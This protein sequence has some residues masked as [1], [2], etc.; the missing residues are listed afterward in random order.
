MSKDFIEFYVGTNLVHRISSSHRLLRGD[1]VN[2]AKVT[3]K[4][5]AVS[6]AIDHSADQ[7]AASVVQTVRIV[8]AKL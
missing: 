5:S 3:Y 8:K 2:I 7:W 1:L 6:F 4:V